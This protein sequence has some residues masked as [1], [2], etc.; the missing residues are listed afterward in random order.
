[1]FN[2]YDT[3]T[4]LKRLSGFHYDDEAGVVVTAATREQWN[5]LIKVFEH[6]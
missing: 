2:D 5:E 3:V 6:M 1:L 4:F